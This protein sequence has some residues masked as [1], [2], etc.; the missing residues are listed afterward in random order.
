[1]KTSIRFYNDRKSVPS[2]SVPS[3]SV[4]STSSTTDAPVPEPVEGT[5]TK[6]KLP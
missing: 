1:M 5:A 4:V 2:M 6:P 3:T